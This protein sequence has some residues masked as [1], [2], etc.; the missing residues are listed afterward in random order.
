M[1]FTICIDENREEEVLVYARGVSD[2]TRKLE[3]LCRE[4]CAELLGYREGQVLRLRAADIVCVIIES[5]RVLALTGQGEY[6]LK[7]RMYVLEERLGDGFLK[8]N[9]S[10]LANI[11]QIDRFDASLTG[12]LTVHFKNGYRDYVSRRNLKHVKERFGMKR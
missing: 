2:F 4:E 10:C 8:L 11:S 12:T 9:Q 1:K 5:G 3:Q 6:Q 7:D